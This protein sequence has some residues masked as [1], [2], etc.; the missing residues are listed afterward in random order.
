MR[1]QNACRE[2]HTEIAFTA[3]GTNLQLVFGNQAGNNFNI[4]IRDC[5]FDKEHGKVSYFFVFPQKV[6]QR[7]K[8]NDDGCKKRRESCRAIKISEKERQRE[9]ENRNLAWSIYARERWT[10]PVPL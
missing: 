3:T 2:G 1:F 9:R 7:K 8:V 4:D 6:V 10:R 5:D